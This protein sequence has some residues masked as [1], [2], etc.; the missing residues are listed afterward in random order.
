LLSVLGQ[1][2]EQSQRDRAVRRLVAPQ[3]PD[4]QAG[5]GAVR[6]RGGG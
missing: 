3:Q 4:P 2:I 6:R 5:Q 1:R